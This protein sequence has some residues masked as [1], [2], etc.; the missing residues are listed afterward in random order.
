M[1]RR[2]PIATAAASQNAHIGTTITDPNIDFAMMAKSMGVYA[3]GPI[4]NPKDARA[5]AETRA[6]R[7]QK[8]SAGA[9]RCHHRAAIGE[10]NEQKLLQLAAMIVV[11]LPPRH[12]IAQDAPKADAANGQ[13]V[14]L[15][16]GCYQ[17]HGRVGQGGLMTG[18]API[19]AQT[20]TAL[21]RLQRQVR[22]PVN[23]MPPIRLLLSEK[24]LSTS[25]LFCR[26]CRAATGQG[27]ADAQ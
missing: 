11:R 21:C 27:H 18:P 10:K 24:D 20:R 26:R 23:D 17:C 9:G 6:G 22:N 8:G 4:N 16:D 12:A 15:A 25:S 7:G 14:Y 1:C 19:L 2:C 3:E 5:G 13:K